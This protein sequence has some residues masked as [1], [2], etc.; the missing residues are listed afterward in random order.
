MMNSHLVIAP[1]LL[2]FVVGILLLALPDLS[3]P[4]RRGIALV[5]V[6]LQVIV[7]SMLLGAVA[8][9]NILVYRLGDWPAPFGIVLVADRLAAWM[10]LIT[11]LLSL[12]ALI[13]ASDG[14]DGKGRHFHVLFQLQIFGLSG[15]FLSGDLFNLFVFFEIL[16]IASYSLLLHGGGAGRTR[17][18]LHYV[19]MN[20]L[21]STAF[22]FAA[23]LVYSS[24][25]SLNLADLAVKAAILEPDNIVP[26]KVGGLLLLVVFG[27][28]AGLLPLHLWLP[29]AYSETSAPVAALFSIMTKMGVYAVLRVNM[30]VFSPNA[31]KLSQLYDPWLLP[32]A[33][34]TVMIGVCGVLAAK[35]LGRLAAYMIVISVGTLLIAF[36]LG[37]PGIAAGLYYLPNS[38]FSAAVL[39][40][41]AE[42]LRRR[43]HLKSDSF[44]PDVDLPHPLLW[45]GLFLV[46]VIAVTGLPPLSGFLG[47]LLIL[48]AATGRPLLWLII[49]SSAFAAIAALA[50]AGSRIFFAGSSRQGLA[51]PSDVAREPQATTCEL[52]AIFGLLSLIGLLTI[53]AGPIFEFT[54]AMAAQLASPDAYIHAVLGGGL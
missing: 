33:S 25:G 13:H 26:A 16:L 9:G 37:T 52:L 50:L 48:D 53:A 44:V 27:L 8:A 28:K 51:F 18:G 32:I 7:A 21:G 19:V 36:T 3:M 46:S 39:F 38:S 54:Q 15:A 35:N 12:F 14:T 40:L 22:L 6:L 45:G 41:M 2:P 49:L 43:R 31:G 5:A 47:K 4:F 42:A 11:V 20:L 23:G 34:G 1:I 29:A 10:V 24:F 30:L 17:A